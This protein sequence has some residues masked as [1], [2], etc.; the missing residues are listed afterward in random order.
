MSTAPRTIVVPP[1]ERRMFRLLLA[2]TF[3]L[4]VSPAS[5]QRTSTAASGTAAGVGSGGFGGTGAAGTGTAGRSGQSLGAGGLDTSAGGASGITREFGGTF[6]GGGDTIDRF[7]GSA[8]SDTQNV[9]PPANFGP[10]QSGI[11][12]VEPP[13]P[14]RS[15][16][17]AQL[18]LGFTPQTQSTTVLGQPL[19]VSQRSL[20]G[21]PLAAPLR[22]VAP[23][24]RVEVGNGTAVLRGQVQTS[25]ERNLAEAL[26]RLEPGVRR[27]ENRV[28]IGPSPLPSPIPTPL[29]SP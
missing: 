23:S 10:L 28:Q 2:A 17:R 25:R 11:R 18:R 16:V 8:L 20:G 13:T 27:V 3:A 5:A 14:P 26:L 4:L 12:T 7:V 19:N 1:F 22:R 9:I 6:I 29:P 24:L 21:R 15:P